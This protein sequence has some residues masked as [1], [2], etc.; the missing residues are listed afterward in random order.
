MMTKK[1]CLICF[2]ELSDPGMEYH[3]SCCKKLFLSERPPEV[4]YLLSD[5]EELAGEIIKKH[6]TVTGVQKKIS[7]DILSKPNEQKLTIVG[8]WGSYIL[9]PPPKNYACLPENEALTMEMAELCKI[10][11]VP[12][13]LIRLKS[14]ELAYIT[15]R[16][17]RNGN[18]KTHMEDMC[19][20][21]GRLTED[22]YKGSVEQVGKIVKKHTL[23]VML[24]ISRLFDVVVF[25]FITGNSDMHLKN[26]SLSY[27]DTSHVSLSP[28]YDLLSTHLVIPEKDD[29]EESALTINGKKRKLTKGDFFQLGTSWGLTEKQI[30]NAFKKIISKKAFLLEKI[31][32]SFLPVDMKKLYKSIILTGIEKIT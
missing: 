28:A 17:D 4:P 10:N 13:G 12:H 25:S 30:Q 22:K 11:T 21:S 16:I 2:E 23:N 19:Q 1:K 7:V 15:R 20:L 29:N 6:I 31:N 18:E 8:L 24:E 27:S 26:F 9:K 5:M 32:C 14:G 3:I